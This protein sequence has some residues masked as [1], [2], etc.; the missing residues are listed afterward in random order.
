MV[1]IVD[2]GEANYYLRRA[3]QERRSAL[4]AEVH[5]VKQIH[6]QLAQ[7]LEE[8]GVT[9]GQRQGKDKI[10]AFTPLRQLSP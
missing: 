8:R 4:A 1:I 2:E 3:A 9:L 10:L 5:A 7:M 6:M